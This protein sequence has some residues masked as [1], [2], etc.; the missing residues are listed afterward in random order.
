MTKR[1]LLIGIAYALSFFVAA[2]V[3]AAKP[4]DA[5][6]ELQY[7]FPICSEVLK[8][9]R[10]TSEQTDAEKDLLEGPELLPLLNHYKRQRADLNAYFRQGTPLH[11]AA[12]AGWNTEVL[13]AA[14][15][16]C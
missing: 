1:T 10:D 5:T 14:A 8:A 9:K 6:M 12:C 13:L 7:R 15:Q 3:Q 4:D 2:S 16:W 11:H